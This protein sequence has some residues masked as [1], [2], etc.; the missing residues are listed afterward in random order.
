MPCKREI[1]TFSRRSFANALLFL[2][3]LL[4]FCFWVFVVV[5]NPS[6]HVGFHSLIIYMFV[7]VIGIP[8]YSVRPAYLS[9][10]IFPFPR[11][12]TKHAAVQTE[13]LNEMPSNV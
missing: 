2:V 4:R 6:K 10:K 12:V 8:A 13:M 3:L 1:Y 7:C 11:C 5:P 9:C